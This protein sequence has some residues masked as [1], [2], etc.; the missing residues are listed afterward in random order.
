MKVRKNAFEH[1]YS[2]YLKILNNK[3]VGSKIKQKAWDAICGEWC[4]DWYDEKYYKKSPSKDPRGSLTGTDR[5][6]RG[7]SWD[8]G[9]SCCRSGSRDKFSP[10]CRDFVGL[11]LVWTESQQEIYCT[12]M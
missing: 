8:Y 1:D 7:G 2:D 5:V 12:L 10:S 11:R 4:Q 6:R 9:S 3:Y